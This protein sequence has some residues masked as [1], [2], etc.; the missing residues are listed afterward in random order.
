M[1]LKGNLKP[2]DVLVQQDSP[3][4]SGLASLLNIPWMFAW[5]GITTYQRNY[6]GSDHTN[7]SMDHVM[8]VCDEDHIVNAQPPTVQFKKAA[9]LEQAKIQIYR[10]TFW[11]FTPD[12]G[13]LMIKTFTSPTVYTD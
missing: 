6:F 8:S 1:Q 2:G 5:G 9:D 7:V 11:N 12:D 4:N 10:P 3:F 13:A